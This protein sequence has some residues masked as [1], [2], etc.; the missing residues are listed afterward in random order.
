MHDKSA[1]V[2]LVETYDTSK[3]KGEPNRS[4]NPNVKLTLI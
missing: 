4:L 1:V 3:C 2:S